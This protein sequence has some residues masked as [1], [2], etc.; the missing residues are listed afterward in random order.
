[1]VFR[2]FLSARKVSRSSA[3]GK[4]YPKTG[5][6]LCFQIGR[7][8]S[9]SDSVCVSWGGAHYGALGIPVMEDQYEPV[10]I[11]GLTK[12]SAVGA[13]DYHSMA[14]SDGQLWT[15]GE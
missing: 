4:V 15:W 3:P 5:Q 1:M 6:F 8:S 11:G 7:L 2:T 13:G 9:I 14:I 12:I 10:V